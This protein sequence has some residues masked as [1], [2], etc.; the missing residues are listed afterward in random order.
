MAGH[1]N[2]GLRLGPELA[3][4]VV[5]AVLT[6]GVATWLI[7]RSLAGPA[8]MTELPRIGQLTRA[9]IAD[10][11]PELYGDHLFRT[12]APGFINDPRYHAHQREVLQDCAVAFVLWARV[13]AA[14]CDEPVLEQVDGTLGSVRP[15]AEGLDALATDNDFRDC[16]QAWME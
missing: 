13:A 11:P 10:C 14:S 1:R 9:Q 2:E 7:G 3:L 8:A 6:V 5:F 12:A 15:L 16:Y 4:L